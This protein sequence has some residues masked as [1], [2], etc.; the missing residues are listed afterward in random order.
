MHG[1]VG[2]PQ[3][4]PSERRCLTPVLGLASES[5]VAFERSVCEIAGDVG[6]VVDVGV[7]LAKERE[8]LA[9]QA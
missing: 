7:A 6:L 2:K 8:Q 9:A 1:S 4:L 3:R 5:E